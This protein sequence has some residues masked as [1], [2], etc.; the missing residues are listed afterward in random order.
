MMDTRGLTCAAVWKTCYA[1]ALRAFSGAD[2]AAREGLGKPF[3][4]VYVPMP[5]DE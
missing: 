2:P 4:Q 3:E 5:L 1:A